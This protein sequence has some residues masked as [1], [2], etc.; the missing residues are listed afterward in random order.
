MVLRLNGYYPPHRYRAAFDYVAGKHEKS[1][2]FAEYLDRHARE[3]ASG[4]LH[5]RGLRK[6][7]VRELI[8]NFDVARLELFGAA[9]VEPPQG[10]TL[11]ESQWG[12]ALKV[13]C[14]P[15]FVFF[16]AAGREVFRMEASFQ[17]FHLASGWG[18]WRAGRMSSNRAFSAPCSSGR[19]VSARQAGGLSCGRR[20]TEP[21]GRRDRQED[22]TD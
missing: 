16:N 1:A 18:T 19:S 8:G 2:A 20:K 5:E 6:P 21:P 12:R 9:P 4:H 15:S 11:T 3:P 7:A 10:K 22:L 13:A 14:T 17:P